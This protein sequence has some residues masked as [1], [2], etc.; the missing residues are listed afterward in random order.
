MKKINETFNYQMLS[1]LKH[2]CEYFLNCGK[3]NEKHLWGLNVK[4]HI[5]EMYR[6]WNMLPVKPEWI[7]LKDIQEYE[8]EMQNNS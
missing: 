3:R 8:K 6:Q 7:S 2:D 4:D 1:R 5:T